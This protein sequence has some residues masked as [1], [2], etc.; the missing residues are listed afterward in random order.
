M[1][2]FYKIHSNDVAHSPNYVIY[3]KLPIGKKEAILKYRARHKDLA[4]I[5]EYIRN[6]NY[7]FCLV[8]AKH[9][10]KLIEPV[11]TLSEA[12]SKKIDLSKVNES[13]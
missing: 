5:Y 1:Y 6:I 9:N 7:N 4:S 13:D 2:Y 10:G 11:E 8:P 3:S 12:K